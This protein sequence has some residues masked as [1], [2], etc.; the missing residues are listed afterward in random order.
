MSRISTFAFFVCLLGIS[1]LYIGATKFEIL[2]F[3]TP[4]YF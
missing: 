2:G 4:I 1:K 3:V